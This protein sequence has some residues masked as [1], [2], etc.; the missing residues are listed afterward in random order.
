MSRILFILLTATLLISCE[1]REDKIQKAI[2]TE[3]KG[4]LYDFDSYEP[5]KTTIDSAFFSPSIDPE[6]KKLLMALEKPMNEFQK[7]RHDY[8]YATSIVAIYSDSHSTY[9]QQQKKQAISKRN[10]AEKSI[11]FSRNQIKSLFQDLCIQINEDKLKSREFVGWF[12]TQHYKCKT[13]GGLPT[14]GDDIFVFNPEITECTFFMK[15]DEYETL[16]N[17]I[18][19][20]SSVPENELLNK[21]EESDLFDFLI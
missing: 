11:E 1:S 21:I 2:A 7:A 12:V 13:G 18:E 17:F 9:A 6:I 14:F 10:A 15:K 20:I 16:C 3:L 4:V 19:I 5:I 8:D